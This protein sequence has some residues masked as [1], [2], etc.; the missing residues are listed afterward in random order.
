V[1]L[2]AVANALLS[3]GN[4]IDP[5]AINQYSIALA[6]TQPAAPVFP[7]ILPAPIPL[8][9]LFDFTTIDR[10]I[11]N[12]QSRQ[13]SVEVEQQVGRQATVS[14]GYQY[15]AGRHLILQLNQ[16]VPTC[17]VQGTNNGCRPDPT[18]QNNNQYSSEAASNYH[19]MHVT[20][21][22]RPAGWA[23]Y[24]VSYT[25]SKSMN[26]VGETFFSGPI[27]PFDLSKDWARSDDDQRHRFVVSGS[28]QSPRAPATTAWQRF[29]HGFVIS[30]N[31]Q[32]YSA[33]PY[34]ITT[35]TQTVYG[36][37][38]RPVVDGDY[39]ERNAGVGSAF[40]TLGVRVSRAF[41]LRHATIEGLVEGFNVTNRTNVLARNP[42]FGTGAYPTSPLPDFG[43][44][45]AVGDPRAFQFGIRIRY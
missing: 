28:V 31:L 16:N 2:R 8:V 23:D 18:Y 19:A 26:N 20:F 38:A 35:G 42:V 37:T 40:F 4:T 10:N 12:A 9:T 11:R 27:D 43:K 30:G 29:S 1:P 36:T 7:A 5:N 39:I 33:A 15:L 41:R 44:V 24:R 25:L 21:A 22:Q 6:P 45:T 32:A 13:A 34:N 14:A 3:A 17:I